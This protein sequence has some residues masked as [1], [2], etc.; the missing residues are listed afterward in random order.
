[1]LSDVRITVAGEKIVRL[2]ELGALLLPS[3][4]THLHQQRGR[5]TLVVVP[6]F[7]AV[8]SRSRSFHHV[9][10]SSEG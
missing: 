5:A 7:L 4:R 9:V 1:V 2:D 8:A 6:P 10:A 3:R